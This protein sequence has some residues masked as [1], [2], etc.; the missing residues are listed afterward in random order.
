MADVTTTT[1]DPEAMPI[2]SSA[3]STAM[4]PPPSARDI[5]SDATAGVNAPPPAGITDPVDMGGGVP[6]LPTPTPP[7][8][9]EHV[10]ALHRIL[11]KVGTILGGDETL[12][13]SRDKDGNLSISKDPSTTGEKWGRVAAAALGGAAVGLANSQGPGGA[14]RAFAAGAQ[15]GLQAPQEREKRMD[16]QLTQEEKTQQFNA[17]KALNQQ[18]IAM[19]AFQ[20]QQM[21][22]NLTQEQAD[23]ANKV[24]DW[25]MS[26]PSNKQLGDFNSMADVIKYENTHGNLIDGHTNGGFHTEIV[27]GADG[28]PKV[29][30]FSVDQAWLDQK[31]DKDQTY[32]ELVPGEKLDSPMQ[33]KDHLVKAGTMTN[34]DYEAAVEGQTKQIGDY[35][36]KLNAEKDK[37]EIAKQASQDR[38]EAAAD[39]LAA[40]REATAARA[41]MHADSVQLQRQIAEGKGYISGQAVPP[42]AAG[43]YDAKYPPIQNF[44]RDTPGIVPKQIGK[45]PA[46]AQNNA[47]L[48]RNVVENTNA[49][50]D[51]INR[52]GNDL[53]GPVM[54]RITNFEEM[55]GSDDAD[56]RAMAQRI[57][58]IA[59][60]TVGIHGSRSKDLVHD[61]EQKIFNNFKAGPNG[62]KA[63]LQAN[64]DSAQTF[65]DTE[66]N[67]L[68]YGSATGPDRSFDVSRQKSN[69]PQAK[70][71]SKVQTDGKGNYKELQGN[72]WVDVAPPPAR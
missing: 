1:P 48:A 18:K 7:D 19:N 64:V 33:L 68:R 16:E 51:I 31:L 11:D 50:M 42:A 27:Q 56:M 40:S 22:W 2:E 39:R 37:L 62:A 35:Q 36:V 3:P 54:G 66:K 70:D 17:N 30:L 49:V 61:E 38:R 65:L 43:T 15:K 14:E 60:A 72:Q 69:L 55:A 67:F 26:N 9:K 47:D 4:L 58:N 53:M 25:I 59:K 28:K 5:L 20:L 46:K 6:N 8:V 71:Y 21:G 24:Q 10:S 41:Q 57:S 29:R 23:R 44:A 34:R 52:R 63:A 13:I 45:V 12:R 32:K